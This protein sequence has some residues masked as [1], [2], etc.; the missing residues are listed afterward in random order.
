MHVGRRRGIATGSRE[1][2]RRALGLVLAVALALGP[3][4]GARAADPLAAE[5]FDSLAYV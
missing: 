1:A 2:G 4:V 3:T 5:P